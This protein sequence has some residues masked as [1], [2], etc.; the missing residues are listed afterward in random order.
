MDIHENLL[1]LVPGCGRKAVY[2]DV[3]YLDWG[4]H[5]GFLQTYLIT[6]C[7]ECRD[8]VGEAVIRLFY[9]RNS[10]NNSNP[11]LFGSIFQFSWDD[12][13]PR[14]LIWS[15]SKD[16]KAWGMARRCWQLAMN[17][18]Y[19]P[20]WGPIKFVNRY[21]WRGWDSSKLK[22]QYRP[23]KLQDAL[24]SIPL[25]TALIK[26]GPVRNLPPN[27]EPKIVHALPSRHEPRR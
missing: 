17:G 26:S 4:Y 12:E 25:M 21:D 1:C 13:I 5:D 16:Y 22:Q 24:R 3:L 23:G 6:A 10:Q 11:F 9:I 8:R 14:V 20:S 18:R 19:E 27:W 15:N 7:A 2:G